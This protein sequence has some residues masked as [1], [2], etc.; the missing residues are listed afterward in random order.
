MGT[1]EILF[2]RFRKVKSAFFS[3]WRTFCAAARVSMSV[4]MF[5]MAFGVHEMAVK[6]SMY[7]V[8]PA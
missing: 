6:I 3:I 5:L 1:Q 7:T 2:L 8:S 4:A